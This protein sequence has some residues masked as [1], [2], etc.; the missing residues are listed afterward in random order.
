MG[1]GPLPCAKA[2]KNGLRTVRVGGVAD[3]GNQEGD[4]PDRIAWAIIDKWATIFCP[5][6]GASGGRRWS[7][8]LPGPAFCRDAA[9]LRLYKRNRAGQ[10]EPAGET[11]V[12]TDPAA[13]RGTPIISDLIFDLIRH[14]SR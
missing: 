2:R 1:N 9:P 11:A 8:M 12:R 13:G 3:G 5:A 10:P 7:A 6:L 14:T 4:N